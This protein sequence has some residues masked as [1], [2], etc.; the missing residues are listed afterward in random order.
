MDNTY[1]SAVVETRFQATEVHVYLVV[2]NA[3]LC[4]PYVN[5]KAMYHNIYTYKLKLHSM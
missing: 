2:K 5:F 3:F 4:L 1:I